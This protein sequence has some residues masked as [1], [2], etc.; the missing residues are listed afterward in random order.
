MFVTTGTLGIQ[1]IHRRE[2]PTIGAMPRLG[3]NGCRSLWRHEAGD[4]TVVPI[5][6][7]HCDWKGAPF[8][9]VQR[10]PEGA[11]PVSAFDDRDE[12]WAGVASALRLVVEGI[13]GARGR[14]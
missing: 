13:A 2:T 9:A 10:L 3:L 4:T 5:F 11:A 8:G 6:I 1:R 7:R 14:A 12:A